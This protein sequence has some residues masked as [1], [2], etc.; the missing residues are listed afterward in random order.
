MAERYQNAAHGSKTCRS[1]RPVD[2]T[3][4]DDYLERM[5]A[6]DPE[7]RRRFEAFDPP[8]AE[9]T[10]AVLGDDAD[11][12]LDVVRRYWFACGYRPGVTAYLNF[13]LLAD[14]IVLHDRAVARRFQSFRTM[15]RSFYETDLFI[16]E[17]TDS[18]ASPTGGI[19]AEGVRETLRA[20]FARHHVVGI[21]TWMMAYFGFSLLENVERQV[22][23][24]ATND[25]ERQLHLQYMSRTFRL[26]GVP[27][28]DRRDEL[29]AFARRVES[30]HAGSTS[31]LER[32]ARNILVIGEMIGVPSEWESLAPFLPT[33]TREVFEPL[34]TRVRP[35]RVKRTAARI[36]GR[37]FMKRA[38]GEERVAP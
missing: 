30:V 12:E 36:A 29:V 6:T 37:L 19:A 7:I 32:H 2:P 35:G 4:G 14:F 1:R 16:R 5:L 25:A 17:V 3:L 31:Q 24:A 27:F 20:I 21:P 22:G 13:F 28:C 38:V 9:Y 18:G 15:A 34:Y 8:Y 33:P 10:D 23:E 11:A 26:M